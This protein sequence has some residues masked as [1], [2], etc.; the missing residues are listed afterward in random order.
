M[1]EKFA[2][3]FQFPFVRTEDIVDISYGKA[4]IGSNRTYPSADFALI[5]R[6]DLDILGTKCNHNTENN[7]L[8][9]HL[10]RTYRALI[11]H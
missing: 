8:I 9:A 4:V 1:S 5:E 2:V 10:Y 7:A 3:Y 6:R 11:T